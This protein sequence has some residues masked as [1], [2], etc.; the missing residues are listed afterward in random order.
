MNYCLLS[1]YFLVSGLRLSNE[2]NTMMRSS[3]EAYLRGSTD[4]SHD[5]LLFSFHHEE[6]LQSFG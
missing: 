1:E 4:V 2:G 3:A 5:S 6:N